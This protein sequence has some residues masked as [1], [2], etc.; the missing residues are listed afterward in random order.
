MSKPV[1]KAEIVTLYLT[2]KNFNIQSPKKTENK[3]NKPPFGAFYR[4]PFSFDGS[5][6]ILII[7]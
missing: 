6:S 1:I 5:Q 4:T 7:S 2:I 3:I